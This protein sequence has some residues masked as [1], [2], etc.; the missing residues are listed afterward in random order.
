MCDGLSHLFVLLRL[1]VLDCGARAVRIL[2][3]VQ[4]RNLSSIYSLEIREDES[5]FPAGCEPFGITAETAASNRECKMFLETEPACP[6]G[7][8]PRP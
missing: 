4:C 2:G 6:V 8:D 1:C 7:Q 5:C 3:Q